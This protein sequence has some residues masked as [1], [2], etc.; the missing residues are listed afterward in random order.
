MNMYLYPLIDISSYDSFG[1]IKIKLQSEKHNPSSKKIRI[2][3][4][5]PRE[6]KETTR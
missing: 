3:E 2:R 6:K 4:T 1:Q 5:R